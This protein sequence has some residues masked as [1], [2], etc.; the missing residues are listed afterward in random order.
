[1]PTG[2]VLVACPLDDARTVVDAP[3][4][5]PLAEEATEAGEVAEHPASTAISAANGR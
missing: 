1:M 2:P 5:E 4:A 3:G